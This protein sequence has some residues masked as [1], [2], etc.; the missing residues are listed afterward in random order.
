MPDFKIITVCN[1]YPTEPYYCLDAFIKSLGDNVAL[2]LGTHPG[3]YLGLGSKPKLLYKAIKEELVPEP[4]FI[5]TDCFDLVFQGNPSRAIDEF[6]KI[7]DD[8]DLV[9]SA[10]RN[11]FPADL[12]EQYDSLNT[13]TS[14]KYLNSGFIV[15]KTRALLLALEAMDLDNVPDDYRREDGSMCHINDQEL[16]QYLFLKQPVKIKLDS[17]TIFGNALHSMSIEDLD[18]SGELIKNVETGNYPYSL[19][20]NG[21]AKTDGLREPI[22][23]HLKL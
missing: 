7:E 13:K 8:Y 14:F 11:C 15:G 19:H 3:E 17:E 6:K 5:F 23:K 21:S 16:W 18:F 1:H 10:E 20:M 9:I 4:Y 22:L 2:V 12:K